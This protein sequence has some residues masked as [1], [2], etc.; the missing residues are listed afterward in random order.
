MWV[1]Q[2]AC[3]LTAAQP[4]DTAA[5]RGIRCGR[6]IEVWAELQ[7]ERAEVRIGRRVGLA[8]KDVRAARR[9]AAGIGSK[10]ADVVRTVMAATAQAWMTDNVWLLSQKRW[11]ASWNLVDQPTDV[12]GR[13]RPALCVA[14]Q[15][16]A[17][18]PSTS[19]LRPTTNSP[20]EPRMI[21]ASFVR[22]LTDATRRLCRSQ[23]LMW[24]CIDASDLPWAG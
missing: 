12:D 19:G 1:A 3:R 17:E 5:Q 8:G 9:C 11:T 14:R 21:F 4:G 6:G 10:I 22:R 7:I 15:A 13:R 23:D 24:S 18:P 16:R 2:R 20:T